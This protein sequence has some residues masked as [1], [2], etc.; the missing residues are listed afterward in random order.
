MLRLVN[1][2]PIAEASDNIILVERSGK[3]NGIIAV[4]T[5]NTDG[6][7]VLNGEYTEVITGRKLSGKYKIAPYEALVLK[8]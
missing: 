1:R 5:E 6:Y 8:K 4:E 3:E 2:R 7:I